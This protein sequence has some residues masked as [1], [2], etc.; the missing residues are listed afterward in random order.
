M[1]KN[2]LAFFGGQFFSSRRSRVEHGLSALNTRPI[3]SSNLL[4]KV[5]LFYTR[6]RR[7]EISPFRLNWITSVT[8]QSHSFSNRGSDF[9]MENTFLAFFLTPFCIII[10]YPGFTS[11]T[12]STP[13]NPYVECMFPTKCQF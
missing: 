8:K 10:K 5:A 11:E 6:R 13:S 3:I 12:G 7:R 2:R 9:I 1:G 4:Q